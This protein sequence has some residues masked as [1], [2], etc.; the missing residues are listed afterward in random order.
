M[1]N[2]P[3]ALARGPAMVYCEDIGQAVLAALLLLLV[4]VQVLERRAF[5]HQ[6]GL[7]P[8]LE[9]GRRARDPDRDY[10]GF[11]IPVFEDRDYPESELSWFG[12][13]IIPSR[14]FSKS[15]ISVQ[16]FDFAVL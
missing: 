10:P 1:N 2:V 11:R 13:G 12:T 14:P 16:I 9:H 6:L 3:E 8:F 4:L 7:L 15:R 5:I